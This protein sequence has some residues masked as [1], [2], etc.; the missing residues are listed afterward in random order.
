MST[1]IASHIT[2]DRE[3]GSLIDRVWIVAWDEIADRAFLPDCP[4]SSDLWQLPDRLFRKKE[5][6]KTET[7]IDFTACLPDGIERHSP[8]GEAIVR[9][10]KR[11]AVLLATQSYQPAKAGKGQRLRPPPYPTTFTTYAKAMMAAARL[12]HGIAGRNG[13]TDSCPDGEPIFRSLSPTAMRQLFEQHQT[14]SAVSVRLNSFLRA[15]L[16]DDWPDPRVRAPKAPRTAIVSTLPYQDD[17]LTLIL[18]FALEYSALSDDVAELS[19]RLAEL[20][21][22]DL[23]FHVLAQRNRALSEFSGKI[24]QPGYRFAHPLIGGRS[25]QPDEQAV[26][27]WSATPSYGAYRLLITAIQ[28]ANAVLILAS[29]AMRASELIHLER[30]CL[31]P[32]TGLIRGVTFKTS[33]RP[34]GDHRDWPANP[35]ALLAVERQIRL[36]DALA[37]GGRSLWARTLETGSDD[38]I[39]KLEGLIIDSLNRRL[40]ADGT[41]VQVDGNVNMRRFRTSTAR[42]IGLSVTGAVH[43]LFDVLGHDDPTV[44]RGYM[45]SDPNFVR[46]ARRIAEEVRRARGQEILTSRHLGGGAAPTILAFRERILPGLGKDET[47]VDTIGLAGALF[48]DGT[49]V[50]PGVYC[51]ASGQAQGPC[52]KGIGLRDAG[53]CQPTCTFRAETDLALQ[54]RHENALSH[55]DAIEA[56]DTAESPMIRAFHLNGFFGAAG[57]FEGPLAIL[58]SD[59]RLAEAVRSLDDTFIAGLEP[60]TRSAIADIRRSC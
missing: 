28:A 5:R 10:M 32:T 43:V 33:D 35:T 29:T 3:T 51:L 48:G 50:R 58:R 26:T 59:P 23:P 7:R 4:M 15:G 44:S 31:A 57:G 18:R 22:C 40:D 42:L 39:P 38:D 11:L 9:R 21:P 1:S 60:A 24:L 16:A 34:D 14:F 56:P 19:R 25:R 52:A 2:E 13:A 49:Q 8:E 55:L 6:G 54:D 45:T 20:P 27:T 17:D 46:D 41:K 12:A 30:D 37:P 47:G 36:A 53:N